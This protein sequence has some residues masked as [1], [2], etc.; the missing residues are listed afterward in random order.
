MALIFV[1]FLFFNLMYVEL[2]RELYKFLEEMYN[3][4]FLF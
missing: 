2:K 3:S 1:L 4:E